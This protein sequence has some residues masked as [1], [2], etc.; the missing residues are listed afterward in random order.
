MVIMDFSNSPLAD[1]F[2]APLTGIA[3]RCSAARS[4]PEL[5]DLSWLHLGITRVLEDEP[6]GRAFLQ[7]IS[8]DWHRVPARSSFFDSLA[9]RRRLRF[10]REANA[11]L[12]ALMARTTVSVFSLDLTAWGLLTRGQTSCNRR[13]APERAIEPDRRAGKWGLM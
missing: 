1:R 3:D 2:F 5:P 7:S 11:A 8:A 13:E 10:C 4:C 6:S 12:C 9:S